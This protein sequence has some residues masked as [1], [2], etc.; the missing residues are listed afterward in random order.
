VIQH[1]LAGWN[2]LRAAASKKLRAWVAQRV[3]RTL[4]TSESA[5]FGQCFGAVLRLGE[6]R[7]HVFPL[8]GLQSHHHR[9]SCAA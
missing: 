6:R 2:V 1:K 9:L 8:T 3:A 5:P 7:N 4:K